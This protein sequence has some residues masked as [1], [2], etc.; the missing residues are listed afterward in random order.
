MAPAAPPGKP[1]CCLQAVGAGRNGK[2][3]L[4]AG[5]MGQ[6]SAQ[7]KFTWACRGAPPAPWTFPRATHPYLSML[8]HSH[9]VR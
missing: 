3:F 4:Q 1:R 8:L 6:Q 2:P 5:R 9:L 7:K